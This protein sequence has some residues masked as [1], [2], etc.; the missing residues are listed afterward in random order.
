VFG[1]EFAASMGSEHVESG[2]VGG[3]ETAR[4]R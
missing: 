1:A 3:A 2:A 4:Q